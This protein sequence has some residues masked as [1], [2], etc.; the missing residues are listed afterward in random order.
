[1]SKFADFKRNIRKDEIVD[2]FYKNFCELPLY[3]TLPLLY[4]AVL[5]RISELEDIS[6]RF[7]IEHDLAVQKGLNYKDLAL[8]NRNAQIKTL[9]ELADSIRSVK[10]EKY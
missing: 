8:D 1:M 9:K 6:E 2:G 10:C 3:D 5:I 4:E 7:K